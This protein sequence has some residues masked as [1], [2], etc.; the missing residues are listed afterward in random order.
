MK[1]KKSDKTKSHYVIGINEGSCASAALLKDGEII[2]AASEERFSRYKNQWGFPEQAIKFCCD[3]AGIIPSKLD[4]FVLGFE[5]PYTHFTYGRGKERE[6]EIVPSF[7]R[8]LALATPEFEYKFPIFRYLSDV[9]RSYYYRIYEPQNKQKQVEE[10]SRALKISS[11]KIYRVNHHL[12][13][14]YT[15]YFSNPFFRRKKTLVLTCDGMGDKLCAAIYVVENEKFNLIA[16]T[17]LTSS[18]GYLYSAV[19]HYLGLKYHEDEYKVMGLAPYAKWPDYEKAYQVFERLLQLD[20]LVFKT[21][22]PHRQFNYYLKENLQYLRFDYIAAA[23]QKFTEDILIQWSKNAIKATNIKTLVCGG[24][25]FLN[26]KA[27]MLIANLPELEEVF[28]MPS[29]GD[30]TNS[31]GAAYCGYLTLGL[32]DIKPISNLYLGPEYSEADINKALEDYKQFKITRSKHIEKEIASLL[33]KGQVV[34]RFAGRMEMGARALGNRSILADPRNYRTVEKINK[35]IKMRDFWMPFAPTILSEKQQEYIINP[36]NIP[37]PFMAMAFETTPKGRED[38]AAAVHPYDKTARAQILIR[39]DNPGYY[40][41]IK[42]FEKITGVAGLLDTSF[43]IH[44]EPVVCTPGDALSTLARSGL[45][46]LALGP[47][48]VSKF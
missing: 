3:Y 24:G 25:T 2:A 45:E 43:N 35:M 20:G 36:K 48:I 39:T 10:I 12:C 22:V 44:G 13:H 14:A 9:G 41:V 21:L 26:V 28:F 37:S 11:D 23:V 6:D 34:A 42:E 7:L 33:A 29:A 31:F 32:G 16:E 27:N 4:V 17:N 8:R 40:D 19:T 38:L 18:L 30:D 15:A 46:Y 1:R 47:Y 5:D